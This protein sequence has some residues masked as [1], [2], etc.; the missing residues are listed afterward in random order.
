[1]TS[2]NQDSFQSRE[3]YT[4]QIHLP[5]HLFE[6]LVWWALQALPDEILV[7]L[8]IDAQTPH[9]P[10]VQALFQSSEHTDCLF[11][12]HGFIIGEANMVNRVD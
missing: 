7:G 11:E 9:V 10:E 12:G 3:S 4:A 6:E 5:G 2:Y 1:M 8:D